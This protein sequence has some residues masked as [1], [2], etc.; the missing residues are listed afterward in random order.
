MILNKSNIIIVTMKS[1]NSSLCFWPN[2]ASNV[3]SEPWFDSKCFIYK[4]RNKSGDLF[5][6]PPYLTRN[7]VVCLI[8]QTYVIFYAVKL[9]YLVFYPG[10]IAVCVYG[11]YMWKKCMEVFP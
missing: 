4:Y 6:L 5:F 7:I 1:K 10:M 11:D 3:Q 8:N 2:S 9:H